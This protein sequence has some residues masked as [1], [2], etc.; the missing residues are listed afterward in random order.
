MV[1]NKGKIDFIIAIAVTAFILISVVSTA[2]GLTLS[3]KTQNSKLGL[4]DI[5]NRVLDFTGVDTDDK[6]LKHHMFGS[7]EFFYNE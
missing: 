1:K 2:L 6:Y 4:P 5:K 7:Y 3:N